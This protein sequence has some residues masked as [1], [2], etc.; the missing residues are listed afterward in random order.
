[1]AA[2]PTKK[3]GA[4]FS[5]VPVSLISIVEPL[6]SL[7]SRRRKPASKSR[8]PGEPSRERMS[9]ITMRRLDSVASTSRKRKSAQPRKR[10][11]GAGADMLR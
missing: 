2:P 8:K 7:L 11:G 10:S 3:P 1:M 4:Y 9:V 5:D 6:H